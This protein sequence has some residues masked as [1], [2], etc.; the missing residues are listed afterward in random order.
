MAKFVEE[1]LSNLN[2]IINKLLFDKLAV[3][4]YEATVLKKRFAIFVGL[5]PTSFTLHRFAQEWRD[6]PLIEIGIFLGLPH[7]F[8]EILA[9]EKLI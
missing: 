7:E 3:V 1:K 4:S 5:V 9:T 8:G 2:S 6:H